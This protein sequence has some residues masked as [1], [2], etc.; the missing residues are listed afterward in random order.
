MRYYLIINGRSDI[1][2]KVDAALDEQ[3][4]G[5]ENQFRKYYT[6]GIGDGT[7]HVRIFCDLHPKDEVCFIA[8]G[9]CGTL[10]EVSSG[11]VGFENK[12][13]ALLAFGNTND[14]IKSFP[15][16]VFDSIDGILEGEVK[17]MD[18]IKANDFF[19]IN[20]VNIGF[21]AWVGREGMAQME[22]GM[23]GVKAFQKALI[24]CVIGHRF[25][26]IS[27]VADG[28]L[29]NKKYMLLCSLGNASWCGGS[30]FCSP[31]AVVDD[32]LIDLCCL[33]AISLVE[34][35]KMVP[36]YQKGVYLDNPFCK[37]RMKYRR[38]S[39][40]DLKS[41]SLIYLC[42]DGEITAATEFS[43]DLLP[44]AINFIL[45]KIKES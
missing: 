23:E 17:Q 30:F 19:S 12:Y 1:R 29:I 9:G 25:N 11:V 34:F 39:H 37:K 42:I 3:L 28:E 5:R 35:I 7:R 10:N 16:Y 4:K 24:R 45:P 22:A 15:A 21:D 14:F 43:I 20:V 8:C 44:K 40:V 32:G 18:I 31:R 27:V 36:L 2:S 26:K 33:K 6:E 41:E 38:V 13:V